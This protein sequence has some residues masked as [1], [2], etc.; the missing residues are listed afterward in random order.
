MIPVF[1][2]QPLLKSVTLLCIFTLA[3][4]AFAQSKKGMQ[5]LVDVQVD[6]EMVILQPQR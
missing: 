4:A 3:L 1:K 5:D 2:P 6:Q